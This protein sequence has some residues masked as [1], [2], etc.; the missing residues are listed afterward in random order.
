ML[1]PVSYPL[2][3]NPKNSGLAGEVSLRH[4]ARAAGLGI[5]G[6]HKLTLDEEGKTHRAPSVMIF[7]PLDHSCRS[8]GRE[9][10]YFETGMHRF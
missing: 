1:V 9:A 3:I 6:R 8:R 10:K 7:D 4:A 2:D 5:F